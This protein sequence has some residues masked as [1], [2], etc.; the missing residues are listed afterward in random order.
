LEIK[1]Q[2]NN[3]IVEFTVNRSLKIF[4]FQALGKFVRYVD[5]DGQMETL[6]IY[7]AYTEFDHGDV[8]DPTQ[9]PNAPP[10]FVSRALL[11]L[12]AGEITRTET[13]FKFIGALFKPL[14]QNLIRCANKQLQM[15]AV[16]FISKWLPMTNQDSGVLGMEALIAGLDLAKSMLNMDSETYTLQ[17]SMLQRNRHEQECRIATRLRLVRQLLQ[18]PGTWSKLDPVND[19]PGFFAELDSSMINTIGIIAK[20]PIHAMSAV[21]I[22]RPVP[23][24]PGIP[25]NVTTIPPV[26]MVVKVVNFLGGCRM[27]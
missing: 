22:S 15:L 7:M 8:F 24:I 21:T 25:N 2:E 6:A 12:L 10:V 3:H 16:Q 26:F 19:R 9:S 4:L 17:M 11:V 20:L 27:E 1:T 23:S 5:D 14:V 18:T 13:N